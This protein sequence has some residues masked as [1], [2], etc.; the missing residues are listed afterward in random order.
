MLK[1]KITFWLNSFREN[2]KFCIFC[3]FS[4]RAILKQKFIEKNPILV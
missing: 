3:A 4:K 1:W 2:V